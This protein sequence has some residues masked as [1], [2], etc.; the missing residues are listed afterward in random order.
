MILSVDPLL[1]R[2]NGP[3][4]FPFD[5]E[6]VYALH[7]D[8]TQDGVEDLTFEVVFRTEFR[9]NGVPVALIGAGQ[10]IAGPDN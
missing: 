4:Y 10:N 9:L 7:V 5:N 3:N 8:N 6:L 1:E 2:S